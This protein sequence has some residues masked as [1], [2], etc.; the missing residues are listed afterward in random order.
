VRN[1]KGQVL[2]VSYSLSPLPLDSFAILSWGQLC[3]GRIVGADIE[4]SSL[5]RGMLAQFAH[6]V[7]GV[8]AAAL[9]L[10]LFALGPTLGFVSLLL[11]PCLFFLTFGKSR[12]ASWHS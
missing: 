3:R 6:F 9:R 5:S 4:Q 1:G 11:L 2:Q 10:L 12:S 7:R 8:Y